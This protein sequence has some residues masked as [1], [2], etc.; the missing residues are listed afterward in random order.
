MSKRADA[1]SISGAVLVL[2]FG[3]YIWFQVIADQMPSRMTGMCQI[4]GVSCIVRVRM[5][6]CGLCSTA[7]YVDGSLCPLDGSVVHL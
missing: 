3:K 1:L 7:R 6:F 4:G 5:G 2:D